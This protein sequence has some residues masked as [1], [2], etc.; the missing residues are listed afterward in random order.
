ME[1]RDYYTVRGVEP[2]AGE[3]EIKTAYGRLARKCQP[4]VSK[5]AG[6]EDRVKSINEAYEV[7]RDS[8]KLAQYDQLRARGFRPGEEF[9]PPP[10]YH[11]QGAPE[12]GFDVGEGAGFSDLDRKSTRLNSSH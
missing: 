4:E 10:G 1:F 9:R 6:A 2:G 3:A 8:E 12:Y 5:E 7:L 11:G